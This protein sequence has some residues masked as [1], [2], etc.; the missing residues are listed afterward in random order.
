MYVSQRHHD[1]L[2]PRR[3][4]GRQA[5]LHVQRHGFTSWSLE[6]VG[7]TDERDQGDGGQTL[8]LYPGLKRK[9]SEESEDRVLLAFDQCL[10]PFHCGGEQLHLLAQGI[11]LGQEPGITRL[12]GLVECLILVGDLHNF[13]IKLSELLV[14]PE[15]LLGRNRSSKSEVE[16]HVNSIQH[17]TE[18]DLYLQ[19]LLQPLFAGCRLLGEHVP[20][21]T[22]RGPGVLQGL[23]RQAADRTP[24]ASPP[25]QPE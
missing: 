8:R 12:R 18:S 14:V 9:T 23:V 10:L 20:S 1:Q 19:S 5:G 16:N 24:C 15:D 22:C 4:L 21:P 3:R 13:Q 11:Q 2:A 17:P 6:A 7:H 25:Y